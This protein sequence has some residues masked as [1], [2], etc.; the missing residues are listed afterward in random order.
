MRQT[1]VPDKLACGKRPANAAFLWRLSATPPLFHRQD[2]GTR[3]RVGN[4][5]PA[6][7]IFKRIPE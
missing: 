4:P 5:K 6:A 3:N 1:G 2:D 7:K